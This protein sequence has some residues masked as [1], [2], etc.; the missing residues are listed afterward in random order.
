MIFSV[1]W[2]KDASVWLLVFFREKRDDVSESLLSAS[3]SSRLPL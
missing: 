2:L 1:F 3:Q